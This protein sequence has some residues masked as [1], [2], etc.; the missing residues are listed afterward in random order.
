MRRPFFDQLGERV[1]MP[2]RVIYSL[3]VVVWLMMWQRLDGRGSLATA[4]QQVVQGA[5]GDLVP[6]EKRVLEQRVSSNTGALSRARKRR[7][8]QAVEAF[9]DEIFAKLMASAE[10]R[11]GLRSRLF[12][13]DGSTLRLA[14][15][16]A[17]KKAYPL[18]L[19]PLG[20][21]LVLELLPRLLTIK[22]PVDRD[23]FPI[24]SPVPG[25][26]FCS[27][28]PNISDPALPQ[29]LPAKQA[30]L[31]LRLVQPTSMHRCVVN[32]ELIPQ[33]STRFGAKPLH[34]RLSGV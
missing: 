22:L 25:A 13:V 1:G 33:G 12:L 29:A 19:R 16:P 8:L 24:H 26:S 15:T 27:Q 18:G 34:Q 5:L 21:V 6:P 32:G 28:K 10:D 14:H 31:Q 23:A 9:C 7:P 20:F 30:D 4:V 2:A 17:L 11:G 3:A